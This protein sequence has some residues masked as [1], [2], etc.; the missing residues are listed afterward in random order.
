MH[1]ALDLIP[2]SRTCWYTPAVPGH[3]RGRPQGQ[4]KV[5]FGDI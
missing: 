5:I 4:F 3:D 2:R 1:R